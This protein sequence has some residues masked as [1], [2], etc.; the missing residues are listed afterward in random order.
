MHLALTLDT[1]KPPMPVGGTQAGGVKTCMGQYGTHSYFQSDVRFRGTLEWGDVREEVD[2]DSGWIDRQW[3]PRHLGTH[4]D[5]RNRRYRHEWRQIHL[6]N[7]M[8][9][10][11]WLHVDRLRGNRLDSVLRRD[12]GDAGRARASPPASSSSSGTRTCA[13]PASCAR[14]AAC[15]AAPNTLPTATASSSRHGSST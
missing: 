3:T 15:R 4:N 9:M 12:R 10:S 8:E 11:V 1:L 2:G 13:T 7:G 5:W 6:D 14:A